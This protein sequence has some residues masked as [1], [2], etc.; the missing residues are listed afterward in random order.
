MQFIT[1][2]KNVIHNLILIY[3]KIEVVPSVDGN[4]I[5]K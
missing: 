1:K 4:D 5:L 2:K 3:N